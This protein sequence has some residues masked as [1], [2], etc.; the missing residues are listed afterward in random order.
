MIALS[1]VFKVITSTNYK[2]FINKIGDHYNIPPVFEGGRSRVLT[3]E[4]LKK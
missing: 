3:I 4:H 2:T 1:L